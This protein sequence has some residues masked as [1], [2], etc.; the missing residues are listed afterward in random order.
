M[1]SLTDDDKHPDKQTN[2]HTNRQTHKQT[3]RQ[4]NKQTH[5]Q[6]LLKT[7]TTLAARVATFLELIPQNF[8]TSLK[9]N[10]L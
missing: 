5:K 10:I 2:K 3:S 6:T 4:T 8:W 7:N 9:H 1:I